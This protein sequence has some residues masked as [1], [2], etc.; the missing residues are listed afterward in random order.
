ITMAKHAVVVA[1][2]QNTLRLHLEDGEQH[3][4]SMRDPEQYNITTF[5]QSDVPIE[6]PNATTQQSKREAAAAEMTTQEL[7]ARS[8]DPDASKAR[9]FQTEFQRRLALPTS[10][11]VLALVGIPLGLSSRKGGK[12]TGFVLAIALVFTYY[13]ISL[14]GVAMSRQGKLPAWTAVWSANIVFAIAGI[15][16]LR[17]VDRSSLEIGSVKALVAPVIAFFRRKREGVERR[18]PI[19]VEREMDGSSRFPSLLDN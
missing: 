2:D 14:S 15:L 4:T 16:L 10:C 5:Q 11:L 8:N 6:L 19:R 3:Q 1:E 17:R 7:I 18:A 13:L 9:W 12:A